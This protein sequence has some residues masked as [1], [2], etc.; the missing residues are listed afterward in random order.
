[1]AA[2]EKNKKPVNHQARRH[3]GK[4]VQKTKNTNALKSGQSKSVAKTNSAKQAVKTD[5]KNARKNSTKKSAVKKVRNAKAPKNI[6][7]SFLGGLGEI[8]KNITVYEYDGE[9]IIVDCGLAFPDGN[10]H[11]VD[12][13]IPDFTYLKENASKIK[14]I[15]ITHGHEDH[16]GSLAYLMK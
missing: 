12:A 11:G 3:T 16:I 15:L 7:I 8:G 10:M 4:K 14:A 13:V 6:S 5:V 1:M 9:I 2:N